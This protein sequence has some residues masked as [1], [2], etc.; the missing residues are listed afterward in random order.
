[1]PEVPEV[2]EVPWLPAEPEVPEEPELPLKP[3]EPDE[4]EV[5]A[6]ADVPLL[7]DVPEVPCDPSIPKPSVTSIP[8]VPVKATLTPE[9]PFMDT[10]IDSPVETIFVM[11][12]IIPSHAAV[13]AVPIVLVTSYW[14]SSLPFMT[15]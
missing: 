9:L 12:A 15:V 2:P 8:V 10:S 4:P 5:P 1:M 14:R 11:S 13:L 3:E 7:P 6:G